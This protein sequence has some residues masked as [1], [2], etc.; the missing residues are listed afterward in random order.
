MGNSYLVLG[1]QTR[2]GEVE[3]MSN[4]GAG[5]HYEDV[6]AVGCYIITAVIMMNDRGIPHE[7]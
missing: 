6:T 2:E 3:G 5:N 7:A 4:N 1:S